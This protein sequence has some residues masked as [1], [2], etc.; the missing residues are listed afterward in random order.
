MARGLSKNT[1]GLK[2]TTNQVAATSEPRSKFT[3]PTNSR[4]TP[5]ASAELFFS[6]TVFFVALRLYSWTLGPTV[7]LTDSGEV[8][9]VA[10]GL[11]IAH[12]PGVPLWI[13]LAHLA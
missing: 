7:T 6:G 11:G 5:L 9:V 2:G 13:I 4:I 10:R 8:I 12:P 1:Q 3:Q